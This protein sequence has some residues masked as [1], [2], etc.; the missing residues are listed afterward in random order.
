MVRVHAGTKS[1]G[2]A[3][4]LFLASFCSLVLATVVGLRF[5]STNWTFT[6][7]I[8]AIMIVA[9]VVDLRSQNKKSGNHFA[10]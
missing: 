9:A 3:Q 1:E 7:G 5:G 10:V 4:L 6:A 8:L 2:S